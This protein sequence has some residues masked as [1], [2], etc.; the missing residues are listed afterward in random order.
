MPPEELHDSDLSSVA[1]STTPSTVQQ[2]LENENIPVQLDESKIVG[3]NTENYIVNAY[4]P[5]GDGSLDGGAAYLIIVLGFI[6]V[7][8]GTSIAMNTLS[9]IA[10]FIGVIIAFLHHV[11][12]TKIINHIHHGITPETL[13]K[14]LIDEGLCHFDSGLE[15]CIQDQIFT[16]RYITTTGSAVTIL[17]IITCTFI[18]G[19]MRE[20]MHPL[21]A[22]VYV[23]GQ[24]A[25]CIFAC[26]GHFSPL[27]DPLE[28]GYV[29]I[30]PFA[31]GFIAKIVSALLVYPT[32]SNWTFFNG[33][34]KILKGLKSSSEKNAKFFKTMK[35]SASN[36]GNYK[37]FKK[38]ILKLRGSMA[39]LE[40]VASTIW[41]EY[42]YGRFDVGDVGEFRSLLKNLFTSSSTYT[43]FYQL[44]EERTHFVR[45]EFALVRKRSNASSQ[46]ARKPAF[47]KTDLS[48]TDVAEY[49]LRQRSKI[50]KS[51]IILQGEEDSRLT[52]IVIDE[53][54][55]RISQYFAGLLDNA[56]TGIEVIAEWLEAANDFRIFPGFSSELEI[57]LAKFDNVETLK[58]I[59]IDTSKPEKEVLF[60]ISQGVFFLQIVKH[61]CENILK[62]LDYCLELDERRPTPKFITYFSKT[63][64]SEPKHLSNKID[65]TNPG[66][67]NIV[68]KR[69]ADTLP[70]I[71]LFQYIG[72][73]FTKL[74][75]YLISNEFWFW[76]KVGGIIT[77]GAIP[78]F[79]RPLANLY[80]R[81]RMIWLVIVIAVSISENT[82]SSVYVVFARLCYSFFGAVVGMVAWYISCGNGQG[83]YYGYGAV[84]AVLFMY[85]IYFRHFSVHQTLLPQILYSVT[86]V[87][88]LGTSWVDAKYNK[89]ANV[90]VGYKPAY[91][92]FIGV[93]I[94][95]C[96][97]NFALARLETPDYN[98]K[99][100]QDAVLS[101]YSSLLMRMAG[102]SKLMSLKLEVPI[103]GYWPES[104]YKRLSGLVTDVIQLYLMLSSA[105]QGLDGPEKWLPVVIKRV[106]FCF[107]D[108]QAEVFATIHMAS[109]ALR[110]KQALPKITEANISLKH[111]ELLRQQWG[112]RR[113]S[114]SERFY[115]DSAI[116]NNNEN[117]SKELDHYKLFSND[118]QLNIMSLLVAHMIYNRLDEIMILV[119]GLVGEIYD[120]NERILVDEDDYFEFKQDLEFSDDKENSAF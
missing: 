83:N 55:T 28:I 65:V 35:P 16:G 103:A 112:L 81:N 84:T 14:N 108:L 50:M 13:T 82:G 86:A 118:G 3:D 63:K 98:I 99:G 43:Y 61:Q 56:D 88:V 60:L 70:P 1:S 38:E 94:G 5:E 85:F 64:Y 97:A 114:L 117:T 9:S 115:C 102:L 78:Y 87:L 96:L 19:N 91:L 79:V 17:S 66:S 116:N 33:Y 100:R 69:N 93:A 18:V 7:S 53:M 90:D 8:G 76:I 62:V 74:Y 95:L 34:T 80:Y 41:L 15:Q 6:T 25:I 77:I 23:S 11:I 45:N 54:A 30:K 52:T 57:E 109:D 119:K 2:S 21:W 4:F 58:K 111:M 107:P 44:L 59:M 51:R 31:L 110:T 20:H 67:E 26:Y 32:T 120:L 105:L 92:R 101:N 49:E 29:V 75:K 104:K 12:T 36:F 24:I 89:L 27:F 113:I 68:R 106:G 48:Y 10:G 22:L 72:Y 37:M 39:P 47:D 46:F 71:N 40:I 73:L 42:S